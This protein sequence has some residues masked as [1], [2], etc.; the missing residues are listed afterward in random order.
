MK[1][2][3]LFI[4][5]VWT[6]ISLATYGAWAKTI[7]HT[8]SD[9]DCLAEA[10]YFEGRGE[11][12][13]GQIAIANVVLNRTTKSICLTV[14]DKRCIF[15]YWCDGKTESMNNSK[16]LEDVVKAVQLTLDG[17]MLRNTLGA[18][19]YHAVYVSP[20]WAVSKEFVLMDTV[21]EHIFY[22]KAKR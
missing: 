12:F 2:L 11:P 4:V 6:F 22:K 9:L 1:K 8:T 21:G 3:L 18:T 14:H 17:V 5:I 19:H 10:V 16:A 7:E 20:S 13:I 15:S